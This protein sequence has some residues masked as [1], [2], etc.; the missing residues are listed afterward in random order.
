M[1]KLNYKIITSIFVFFIILLLSISIILANN[2]TKNVNIKI[3]KEK[4]YYEIKYFDSK[5]IYM[6]NVLS[7]MKNGIN[8]KELQ[9]Q[10]NDLYNYW[11]SVILD[12]N[13]LDIDKKDLINFGKNL[14]ELTASIKYNEK[15]KILTNLAQLYSKL[16]IY[17]DAIENNNYKNILLTKY[18]LLVAYSIVETENWTLVH[19]YIMKASDHIYKVVNSIDVDEYS[20]YNVNQAYVAVKE[21]ENLINIKDADLFYIKYNIAI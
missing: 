12:L 4:I 1:K 21:M 15:N 17:V 18:N 13:Y 8:W 14:D 16:I 11:N 7:D 10:T 6:A 5:I 9:K 3:N 2:V 19:E 20:Q